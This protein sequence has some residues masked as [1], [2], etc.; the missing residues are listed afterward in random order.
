MQVVISEDT[1]KFYGDQ[2]NT[3]DPS[4]EI[5]SVNLENPKSPSL[6]IRPGIRYILFVISIFIRS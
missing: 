1:Y 6:V 3:L 2:F 4:I 5:F